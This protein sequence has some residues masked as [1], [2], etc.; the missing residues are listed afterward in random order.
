MKWNETEENN[1]HFF[2]ATLHSVE[3]DNNIKKQEEVD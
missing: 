2:S 1:K 3:F